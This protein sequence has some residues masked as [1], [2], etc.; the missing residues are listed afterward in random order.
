MNENMWSV[1]RFVF[2]G[3]LQLPLLYGFW[4]IVEGRNGWFI[5]E[6]R[7]GTCRSHFVDDCLMDNHAT[8]PI[9]I[10]D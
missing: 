9:F 4:F 10:E 8:S 3:L 1:S 2:W 7:Y 5:V 6:G